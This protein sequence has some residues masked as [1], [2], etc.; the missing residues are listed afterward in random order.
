MANFEFVTS[1]IGQRITTTH[2][3]PNI[4]RSKD[5]QTM[6]FG[7]IIEHNITNTF[8]IKSCTKHGAEASPRQFCKK[9]KLRISLDQQCE[10]LYS[11][12]LLYVKVEVYQILANSRI[13]IRE[14]APLRLVRKISIKWLLL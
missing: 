14:Y 3:L 13:V 1:Q 10:M 11:L 9:S 7:Q 2:I 8:L 6:K 4:S 12:S 5:N